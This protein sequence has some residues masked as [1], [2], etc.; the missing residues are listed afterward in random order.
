MC[1]QLCKGKILLLLLIIVLAIKPGNG[2]A[3][4]LGEFQ[5]DVILPCSFKSGDSL[6]IHWRVGAEKRVVHSYY[7]GQD[8]LSDQDSQYMSRTSLFHGEIGQGNASLRLSHLRP[9]DAGVY[10]CY[11]GS[12][13]GKVEVEMELKF[14][15]FLTP[16]M[17]YTIQDDGSQLTCRAFVIFPDV[18]WTWSGA[19]DTKNLKEGKPGGLFYVE[20]QQSVT[21]S[22][23][24]TW[25]SIR[26]SLLGRT[27]NGTWTRAEPLFGREGEEVS[28]PSLYAKE[29]LSPSTPFII[30]WSKVTKAS[31]VVLASFDN[32]SQKLNNH[33]P[34]LS[35]DTKAISRGVSNVTLKNLLQSDE[36]EYLCNISSL[37]FTQ[38]TVRKLSVE[39]N[40]GLAAWK[41]GVII[42][43]LF[44]I[45]ILLAV[46][47]VWGKSK[48]QSE[49]LPEKVQP[50]E[51]VSLKTANKGDGVSEQLTSSETKTE[52][53][54]T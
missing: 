18:E 26:N 35:W 51:K 22:S 8:H 27:W 47:I 11:A 25:C 2:R 48:C 34:R 10:S 33:E 20:S 24:P 31:L 3:S 32:A 4:L 15:A 41:I 30:T 40:G 29:K 6:V 45:V 5:Q 39:P 12:V 37:S 9:D 21:S 52:A 23:S 28:F 14:A 17:E 19:S 42:L 16:A 13:A 38:L 43:G 44:L 1:V 7:K 54:E 36:G 50:P 46:V 53:A 49:P